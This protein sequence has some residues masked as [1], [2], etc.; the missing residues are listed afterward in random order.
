MNYNKPFFG[1]FLAALVLLPGCI[2]VPS[3][4]AQPLKLISGNCMYRDVQGNVIMQS[5]KLSQSEIFSLFGERG[6]WLINMQN[7]IRPIYLS[8]INHSDQVYYIEPFS[9]ELEL[10]SYEFVASSMKSGILGTPGKNAR[11]MDQ[12]DQLAVTALAAGATS[13][14][15]VSLVGAV[16]TDNEAFFVPYAGALIIPLIPSVNAGVNNMRVKKDLR[17]KVLHKK[18]MIYPGD[19][20]S[21][22]VFVKS[23]DYSPTFAV[24][25]YEQNNVGKAITFNVDL[26][27][28][29]Q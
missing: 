2:H 17:D 19:Q 12:V 29:E 3:Y 18:E 26:S 20:L 11:D 21:R 1:L 16:T 28:E 9:I 7:T 13:V 6:S 22:L 14:A 27:R 24:K 15:A 8:I 25:I 10:M 5:K 23:T 4:R